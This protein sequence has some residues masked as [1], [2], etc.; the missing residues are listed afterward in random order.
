M[1]DAHTTGDTG[2]E[3]G[4]CVQAADVIADLNMAMSWLRDPGRK[5]DVASAESLDFA[6]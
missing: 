2:L 4:A 3:S 6:G 5:N 1:A